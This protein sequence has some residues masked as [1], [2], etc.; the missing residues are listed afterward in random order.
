MARQNQRKQLERKTHRALP[1]INKPPPCEEEPQRIEDGF[2]CYICGDEYTRH[3][4]E[5][6]RAV[7]F[8]KDGI[9]T[10]T[11]CRNGWGCRR[12]DAR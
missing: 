3:Q 2:R 6:L 8:V 9:K 10:K 5:T 11:A 4:A 7:L 12:N 1:A